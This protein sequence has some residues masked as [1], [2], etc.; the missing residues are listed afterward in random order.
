MESLRE[1]GC[2]TLQGYHISKPLPGEEFL[3]WLRESEW[4]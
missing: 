2:D 4:G 1:Q 3:A